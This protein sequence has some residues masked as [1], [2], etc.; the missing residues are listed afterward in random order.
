V[1]V[2]RIIYNAAAE[3]RRPNVNREIGDLAS[4]K[5]SVYAPA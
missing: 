5:Q 3:A 4:P 1:K 2:R